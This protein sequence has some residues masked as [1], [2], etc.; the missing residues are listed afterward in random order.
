MNMLLCTV[1]VA[2]NN[3]R[4]VFLLWGLA[5]HRTTTYGFYVLSIFFGAILEGLGRQVCKFLFLARPGSKKMQCL[6]CLEPHLRLSGSPVSGHQTQAS[7]CSTMAYRNSHTSLISWR[8]SLLLAQVLRVPELLC[9]WFN[10]FSSTLTRTRV[11]VSEQ[12]LNLSSQCLRRI[13]IC[14]RIYISD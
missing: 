9:D 6:V 2:C 12:A 7:A 13:S 4:S 8:I 14:F 11:G 5:L 3:N 10:W 1:C